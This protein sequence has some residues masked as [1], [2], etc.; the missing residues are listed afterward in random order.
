M[1]FL[2]QHHA[3]PQQRILLEDESKLVGRCAIPLQ[4]RERMDVAPIVIVV[5]TLEQRVEHSFRNYILYKLHEWQQAL[6]AEAGF[7]AFSEDLSDS[8]QRVQK[9]LG[10]A[11]YQQIDALLQ[12]ALAEQQQGDSSLHRQWIQMMLSQYYDPCM[13]TS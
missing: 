6:G 9:R 8:L 7:I 5:A 1:L 2:R 12:Q 13:N 4:L 11:L 10:G 3:R